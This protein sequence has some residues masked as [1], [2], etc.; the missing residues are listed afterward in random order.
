MLLLDFIRLIRKSVK[1]SSNLLLEAVSSV[2]SIVTIFE[3]AHH[4]SEEL[5]GH[6]STRSR[7]KLLAFVFIQSVKT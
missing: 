2:K 4:L 7:L 1:H 3:L 6:F 5:L